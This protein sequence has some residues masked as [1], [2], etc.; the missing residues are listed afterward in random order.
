MIPD[1][2]LR[3][4]ARTDRGLVRP[5]N[6]DAIAFDEQARVAVLADGMGGYNAGEVASRMATE[7]VRDEL[8]RL[9]SSERGKAARSG[10]LQ[11]LMVEAVQ[12]AN[13]RIFETS[14]T[15][16]ACRGMGTTVVA[17]LFQQDRLV[18][19]HL[20]DSRCYR[21]RRGV[22]T[23]LTHDHSQVQEQVDAG[24]LS[25][26]AARFAPNKNLI[27]RAV[28]VGPHI[29]VDVGSHAVEQGDLYL[30]CSDGLSDM[31][32]AQELSAMLAQDDGDLELLSEALVLA[33]NQQGG[34]DNI[35]V[36]VVS[37]ASVNGT[38]NDAGLLA[39]IR[40]W[41]GRK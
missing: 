8:A 31:L 38:A 21:F 37:V 6:E 18:L 40:K 29:D 9:Q 27:T 12:H 16:P 14:L 2:V 36:I 11:K 25:A 1:V 34:R 30:L 19:A 17:A 23:Q 32:T 33:A 22:L 20:G 28:G 5:H 24:Y 3:F 4:A 13:L 7:M 39:R 35:S 10:Q 15:E 41:L 26:D